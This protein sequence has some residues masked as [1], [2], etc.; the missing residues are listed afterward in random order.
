MSRQRIGWRPSHRSG[1]ACT[2]YRDLDRWSEGPRY[3]DP[4]APALHRP[5]E[6]LSRMID[7][8]RGAHP[9]GAGHHLGHRGMLDSAAGFGGIDV[10]EVG[11]ADPTPLPRTSSRS[12]L[13]IAATPAFAALYAASNGPGVHRDT[14]E[15]LRLKVGR[16]ACRKVG[17][18][19]LR[20]HGYRRPALDR[21]GRGDGPTPRGCAPGARRWWADFIVRFE[22]SACRGARA[23]TS[24]MRGTLDSAAAQ[25]ASVPATFK[26]WQFR[27]SARDI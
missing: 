26:N 17:M 9:R 3:D 24:A 12:V 1:T 23:I 19:A 18:A 21:D 10:A 2:N 7:G 25:P 5:D 13:A 27:P 8:A 22:W 4:G 15:T 6:S 14:D 16:A 20:L 11:D